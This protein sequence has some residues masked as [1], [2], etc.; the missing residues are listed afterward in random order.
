MWYNAFMFKKK[1]PKLNK[2][3]T[4]DKR[5]KE[6]QVNT[7][8]PPSTTSE[9]AMKAFPNIDV[10]DSKLPKDPNE[11]LEQLLELNGLKLDFDVIEDTIPTKYGI[12]KLDKPTLVIK[13]SYVR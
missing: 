2:D 6:N 7:K 12:I 10:T 5:F 11:L 3:G 9:E 4:P 8:V 13:A 1:K